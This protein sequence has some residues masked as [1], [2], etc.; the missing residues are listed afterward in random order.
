MKASIYIYDYQMPNGK[1]NI[2]IN[3]KKVN[4]FENIK[5]NININE[6]L[7]TKLILTI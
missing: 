3:K 5:D 1:A 6:N 7:L 4:C 2:Q